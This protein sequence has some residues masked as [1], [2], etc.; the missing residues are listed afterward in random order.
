MDALVEALIAA[1]NRK[2]LVVATR[3]LDRVLWHGHYLVPH[4]YIAYHRVTYWNK[5][6]HPRV[7]PLYYNPLSLILYWWEDAASARGLA[8]A[9]KA[10]QP[11]R[12]AR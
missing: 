2:A 1:P 5:L 12:P 11:F 10:D 3:A 8:A 7:L 4:W 9:I 6:R